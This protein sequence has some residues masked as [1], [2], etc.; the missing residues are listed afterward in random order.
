MF[1]LIVVFVHLLAVCTALGAII[2][3]DLRLLARLRERRMRLAPPNSYVMRL[4]G[5]ALL[6]LWLSGAVLLWLGHEENPEVLNNPKLIGK[7]VLVGLLTLNAVWLHALTFPWLAHARR[8]ARW[9]F[10]EGLVVAVPVA[11][12]NALWLYCAFLGIAR[13]WNFVVPLSQVL[14]VAALVFLLSLAGVLTVLTIVGRDTERA[15]RRRAGRAT[16]VPG[17]ISGWLRERALGQRA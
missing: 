11:A 16:T 10:M 5:G 6:V 7:L 1:K 4:V 2:A 15:A 12:S 9:S 14:A 13:P 8:V 17:A 3:T